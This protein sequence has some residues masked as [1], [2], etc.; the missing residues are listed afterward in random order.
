MNRRAYVRPVPGIAVSEQITICGQRGV[1]SNGP[2][3]VDSD[4]SFPKEREKLLESLRKN[5]A[6]DEILVSDL[7]VLVRNRKDLKAVRRELRSKGAIIVE[8]R[9]NRRS[10]NAEDFADMIQEAI[11]FWARNSRGWT[12]RQAQEMGAKGGKAAALGRKRQ[13]VPSGEA[14]AIWHDKTLGT[15]EAIE[16]INEMPGYAMEWTRTSLYRKFGPRKIPTGP[17]G[18]RPK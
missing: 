4:S 16:K 3:Y 7:P 6:R 11:D 17:R 13:K 9:H 14:C 2:L 12:K 5:G 18:S 8:G 10:T 1:P 15:E